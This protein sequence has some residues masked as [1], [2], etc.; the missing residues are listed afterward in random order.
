LEDRP[1]RCDYIAGSYAGSSVAEGVQTVRLET[2][3]GIKSQI[4]EGLIQQEEK[5]KGNGRH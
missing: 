5:D 2:V 1:N 4:Y 3:Q